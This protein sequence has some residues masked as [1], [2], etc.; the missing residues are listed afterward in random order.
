MPAKHCDRLKKL[1]LV[2]F[3]FSP[4]RLFINFIDDMVKHDSSIEINIT[5]IWCNGSM[6]HL[7]CWGAIR[8]WYSRHFADVMKCRHA[9]LKIQCSI[10]G[11]VGA[12]PT[13]GT[14]LP[15]SVTA[16][17][18]NLDL[19]DKVQFFAWQLFMAPWWNADMPDLESGAERCK[20]SNRLG[21]TTKMRL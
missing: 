1:V 9:G 19:Q 13:I 6:Q 5:R 2:Q 7:G 17:R 21:A 3:Q 10:M 12:N 14:L 18:Q 15:W 20:S 4:Q 8:I 11:R 16:A